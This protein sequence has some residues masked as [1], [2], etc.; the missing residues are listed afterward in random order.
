MILKSHQNRIELVTRP[1]CQVFLSNNAEAHTALSQRGSG[2]P[3]H[4]LVIIVPEHLVIDAQAQVYR[5]CLN[6]N[7]RSAN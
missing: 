1:A 5:Y 3:K 6:L 7:F 2:E 4:T